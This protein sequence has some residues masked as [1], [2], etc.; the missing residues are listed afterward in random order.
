MQIVKKLAPLQK[1]TPLLLAAIQFVLLLVAFLLFVSNT[2]AVGE[3]FFKQVII[4]GCFTLSI[5]LSVLVGRMLITVYRREADLAIKEAMVEHK[6]KIV[7]AMNIQNR[8]FLEHVER[9][10]D[11]L[12]GGRNS[13]LRDYLECISNKVTRL[14][15]IIQVDN[16]IIGALLKSKLTEAD[17]R[18]IRLNVDI[19]VSLARLGQDSPALARIMGNLIDNAFDAVLSGEEYQKTVS[20]RLLRT[21]PLLQLEVCNRGPVIPEEE[22]GLIFEAGYTR[23]EDGHSG[24]GLHIVKTLTEE[25]S[26]VVGVSSDETNGTR[27]T[28]M[29]PVKY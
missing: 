10:S 22:L 19:D 17:I 28:V 25:L 26:G 27:F 20:V 23:K 9:I 4:F 6:Q 18:R 7:Q 11:L 5:V 29:I 1:S 8:D 15:D 16:P 24:L 12:D 21:G 14:N 13:E 3:K 2:P